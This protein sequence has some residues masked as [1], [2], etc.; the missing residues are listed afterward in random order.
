MK[1][2]VVGFDPVDSDGGVGGFNW[3]YNKVTAIIDLLKNTELDDDEY[4]VWFRQLEVADDMYKK[5]MTAHITEHI[6]NLIRDFG[7]DGDWETK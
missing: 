1:V 4:F 7:S 5:D 2:Y 3:F 6:E